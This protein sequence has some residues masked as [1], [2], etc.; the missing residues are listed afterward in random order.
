MTILSEYK[1]DKIKRESTNG[2]R[3]I[4]VV[5]LILFCAWILIA[6]FAPAPE[7]QRPVVPQP[8]LNKFAQISTG[9]CVIV[10]NNGWKCITPDGITYCL[11]LKSQRG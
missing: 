8:V 5:P 9:S 10:Y 7:I 6:M 1:K 4:I 3:A 11:K 2:I